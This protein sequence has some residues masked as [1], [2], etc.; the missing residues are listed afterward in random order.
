MLE[1]FKCKL[2]NDQIVLIG[3][4]KNE[5]NELQRVKREFRELKMR[6]EERNVGYEKKGCMYVKY[7]ARRQ[8]R[9]STCTTRVVHISVY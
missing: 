2:L 6:K 1:S 7:S 4:K 8:L 9:P 3:N 5:K